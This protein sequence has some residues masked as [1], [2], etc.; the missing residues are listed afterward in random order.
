MKSH[1]QS[2]KNVAPSL[3]WHLEIPSSFVRSSQWIS[4]SK[5]GASILQ[6]ISTA[7][8]LEIMG[9]INYL[10]SQL[11][12]HQNSP[13]NHITKSFFSPKKNWCS[14]FPSQLFST[15]QQKFITQPKHHTH[16][17]FPFNIA[18]LQKPLKKLPPCCNNTQPASWVAASK[19]SCPHSSV[20]LGWIFFECRANP[21]WKEDEDFKGCFSPF[22]KT[23]LPFFL[24]GNNELKQ[25]SDDFTFKMWIFW[26]FVTLP[27]IMMEVENG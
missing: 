5:N 12:P 15:V 3:P 18:S 25:T 20:F 7:V 26:N 14:K 23:L 8:V 17:W 13:I 22:K 1:L 19:A 10:L 9:H 27:P 21:S 16:T 2:P 4:P 6:K 24:K 11:L